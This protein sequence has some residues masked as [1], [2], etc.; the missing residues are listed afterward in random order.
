MRREPMERTRIA[1][2]AGEANAPLDLIG[3]RVCEDT[4]AEDDDV[5]L[6]LIG[7]DD[8]TARD[9]EVDEERVK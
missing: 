9:R 8:E 4:R 7:R 3:L 6:G 1:E 5:A 2:V